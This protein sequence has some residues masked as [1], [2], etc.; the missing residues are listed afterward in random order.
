MGLA[1]KLTTAVVCIRLIPT[2]KGICKDVAKQGRK[3]A[4][5]LVVYLGS[6]RL[7]K[8]AVG[9]LNRFAVRNE[10]RV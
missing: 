1:E 8:L 4:K 2:F 5:Q 9:R 10:K 6:L 7:Q 3:T